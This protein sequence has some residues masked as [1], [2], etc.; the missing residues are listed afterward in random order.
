MAS[1]MFNTLYRWLLFLLCRHCTGWRGMWRL[2]LLQRV[3]E[4]RFPT[5]G[6]I[7][8]QMKWG[9]PIEVRKNDVVGRS[10][11]F[12]GD[13]ERKLLRAV[14]REV[15]AGDTVLDIGANIGT[16]SLFCGSLVGQAGRVFCIE[17]LAENFALLEKNVQRVG[18][19]DRI[20]AEHCA[21]GS[22]EKTI[23]LHFDAQSDNWGNISLLESGG[24]GVEEVPMVRLDTLWERW[25]RPQID[26]VKMDVEG[27]E[28][29]VLQGAAR[30][31]REKPP[32]VWVVEFNMEYLSR[33]ENGVRRLWDFFLQ[34]GYE[35][36]SMKTGEKLPQPPEAHCDVL[37]RLGG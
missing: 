14:E 15:R 33:V 7:L 13:Y 18:F 10:I 31:L 21:L 16:V 32:R 30:M 20:C 5:G 29:E 37:F 36:F 24:S 6:T 34:H 35:P 2:D 8:V 19:A 22:E 9:L 4:Y 1:R 17:P 25:S 26:F 28:Y 11:Y 23:A 12:F 27:Y 3:R